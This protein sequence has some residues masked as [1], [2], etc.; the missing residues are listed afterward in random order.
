MRIRSYEVQSAQLLTSDILKLSLKPKR[1][2]DRLWFYPGQYAAIGFKKSTRPSPMRCFSIVSSPNS[3]LLE[4]SMRI[5][6]DYTQA[7]AELEQGDEVFVRGPYG[8]FVIDENID[9]NVIMLAGGIGIT[10]FMSMIRHA[11]ISDRPTPLTLLYSNSSQNN[12]P[13]YDELLSLEKNNPRFRCAF[14]ITGT[15]PD[16]LTSARV[17]KGRI[18][19]TRL[20]NLTKGRTSEFT[21]F[22]CGP[23]KFTTQMKKDLISIGAPVDK[24]ISEEFS[25]TTKLA[26]KGS[27]I[28]RWTYGLAGASI[29]AA[30]LF[31]MG[32]DLIRSVPV[33]LSYENK[34]QLTTQSQAAQANAGQSTSSQTP[35][36]TAPVASSG[37]S[38]TTTTP[39]DSGSNSTSSASTPSSQPAPVVQSYQPPIS[40]VS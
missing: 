21:Y 6:G 13:F 25:V 5:S 10:P 38:T 36:S 27:A 12:I 3:D 16:R 11:S 20:K 39:T 17:L 22:I 8:S 15:E 2:K 26:G 29:I 31:V 32:I 23:K 40:A 18:N 9:R 37:S 4:F 1:P 30:T 28:N 7:L 24:I 35:S 14:F 19:Q 34:R 33:I